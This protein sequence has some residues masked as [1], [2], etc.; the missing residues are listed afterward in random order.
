VDCARL[1]P[2]DPRLFLADGYHPNEAGHRVMA[3]HIVEVLRQAGTLT[4][5]TAGDQFR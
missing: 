4:V 3:E 1:V 5:L 2:T